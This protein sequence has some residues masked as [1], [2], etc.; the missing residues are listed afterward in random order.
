MSK[1]IFITGAS[2][3]IGFEISKKILLD[4]NNEISKLI[5]C[6][7]ESKEFDHAIFTLNALNK[8][9]KEIIKLNINL[10]SLNEIRTNTKKIFNAFGNIDFLIN[11]AGY[12]NPVPIQ[13]ISIEDF[14][15]T[16]DI[17]LFA[18]F[19]IVQSLLNLGNNF[20]TII[21]IASTAGISGRSGWL[22]YS[23]SKAAL[24]NMSEVMREELGIYG[25]RVIC[26]S[27]GRTATSLRRILA[28]NE[29]QKTIMQPSNIAEIVSFMISQKSKFLDTNNLTL[30]L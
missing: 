25:T 4:T 8:H 22:T 7:R 2:R 29:D 9:S 30:R 1:T 17:N 21:N 5:L 13:Q 15:K 18:P 3:G 27:P 6:A 10:S 14:Q 20:D 16:I 23:C 11:N 26:L 28:P 19:V 12:T 24:I